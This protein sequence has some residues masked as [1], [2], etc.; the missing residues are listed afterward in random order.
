[1]INEKLVI[2]CICLGNKIY[3]MSFLKMG[4]Y[5]GI[6]FIGYKLMYVYVDMIFWFF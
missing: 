3:K 6:N 2:K 1:M 4:L 5:L